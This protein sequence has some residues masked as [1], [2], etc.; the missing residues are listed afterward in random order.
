MI[1]GM[2]TITKS[3]KYLYYFKKSDLGLSQT[4]GKYVQWSHKAAYKVLKKNFEVITCLSSF[5]RVVWDCFTADEW[6]Y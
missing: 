3:S 2:I 1:L 6:W 5:E 4:K